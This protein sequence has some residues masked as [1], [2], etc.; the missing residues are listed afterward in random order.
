MKKIIGIFIAFVIMLTSIVLA[1]GD[2]LTPKDVTMM[3]NDVRTVQYCV[4]GVI[5]ADL[6]IDVTVS[7]VCQDVNGISGC[8]IADNH[9]QT[10]FSAVPVFPTLTLVNGIGCAN[11]TLTT[12][13]AEGL[14]YYTVNGEITGEVLASE[15]GSVITPE[16]GDGILDPGEQCDDGNNVDGDGCQA[17]CTFCVDEDGDDVCDDDDDC[18]DSPDEPVDED[19]C[20]HIQFC[21]QFTCGFSCDYAIWVDRNDTN[22]GDFFGGLRLPSCMTVIEVNEGTHRP[23]CVAIA[24]ECVL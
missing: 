1:V 19:G 18:L 16:C 13:N 15:T 24:W 14:Y 6:T 5:P 22:S 4:D 21:R 23:I 10:E 3:S 20:T 7:N 11:I 2:D 9:T 17:D 8:Q 12:V